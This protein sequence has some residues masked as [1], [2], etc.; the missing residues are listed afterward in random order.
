MMMINPQVAYGMDHASPVDVDCTLRLGLPTQTQEEALSP[1]PEAMAI[2][3]SFSMKMDLSLSESSPFEAINAR[4]LLTAEMKT[5]WQPPV[6]KIES[7]ISLK[8]RVIS[9][10][11]ELDSHPFWVEKRNQLIADT[12]LTKN[13]WP[14][15]S[16]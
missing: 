9:R 11:A 14:R 12:I 15:N 5:G 7:L 4:L 8:E 1:S 6:Q 13:N 3:H 16:K 10:M 2:P